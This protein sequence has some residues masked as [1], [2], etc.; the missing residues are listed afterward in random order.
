MQAAVAAVVTDDADDAAAAAAGGWLQGGTGEAS[1]FWL[2]SFM[3]PA[4]ELVVLGT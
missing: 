3:D 1:W 2:V 4:D